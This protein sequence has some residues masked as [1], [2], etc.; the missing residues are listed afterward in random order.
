MIIC[1][2]IKTNNFPIL[3]LFSQTY[4]YQKSSS[5]PSDN[6]SERF[7]CVG[8]LAISYLYSSGFTSSHIHLLFNYCI[9]THHLKVNKI[10][11]QL[12]RSALSQTA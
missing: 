7:F 2:K 4:Y 1:D 5:P 3:Y 11:T 9:T 8:A 10:R 6:P 12:T